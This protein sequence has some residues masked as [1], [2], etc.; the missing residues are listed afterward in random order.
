M[1]NLK[2][3][4]SSKKYRYQVASVNISVNELSDNCTVLTTRCNYISRIKKTLKIICKSDGENV[5]ISKKFCTSTKDCKNESKICSSIGQ[6]GICTCKSEYIG[7]G[8][9]CLK[10]SLTLNETCQRNEQ[11]TVVLVSVCLNNTCTCKRGYP[12]L[13]SSE[14]LLLIK[15]DVGTVGLVFG[16]LFICIILILI[17]TIIYHH[18]RHGKTKND[19]KESIEMTDFNNAA[20]GT[21]TEAPQNNP[22]VHCGSERNEQPF[23]YSYVEIPL[24]RNMQETKK[25]PMTN[26]DI[27]DDDYNHLNEKA[28]D[29][30]SDESNDH[31]QENLYHAVGEGIYSILN[32]GRKNKE[33][34][35]Y[36]T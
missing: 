1:Q 9:K 27:I 16:S 24:E 12:P 2:M 3:S 13:N 30:D 15:Q 5:D 36:S 29:A 10:G 19:A 33:F 7:F 14:C 26:S 34:D 25:Q 17:A 31:V 6:I 20:Y 4:T 11:C 8:N 22:N 23:A 35:V 18:V 32:T 28:E 21:N